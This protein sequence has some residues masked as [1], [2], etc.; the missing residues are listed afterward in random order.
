M[1]WLEA[2]PVFAIAIVVLIL[3]GAIVLRVGGVR[4]LNMLALA[5]PTSISVSAVSAVVMPFIGLTFTPATYGLACVLI[6]LLSA[7][8][9][10][11]QLRR[12]PN[13][14][15][16]SL[17]MNKSPNSGGL[18]R[19]AA[20]ISV[21]VGS[22]GGGFVIGRNLISSIESPENISQTFDNV[23]HLNAVRY[24]AEN[25]NGS[26]LT[27]GNLTEA[28]AGFYPA[29]L[30][31]AMS[32]VYMLSGASVPVTVN[33]VSVVISAVLWPLGCMMLAVR[34]VGKRPIPVM[35]AGFLSA[36]FSGFPYLLIGFGVL[37]SLFAAIALLPATLALMLEVLGLSKLKPLS[38]T[39]PLFWLAIVLPG[40]ALT[41]PSVLVA[42]LLFGGVLLA[43]RVIRELSSRNGPVIQMPGLSWLAG[44]FVYCLAFAVVWSVVRPNLSAAPWGAQQSTS[45][46]IGEVIS[47]A[48]MGAVAAWVLMIFTIAGAYVIFRWQRQLW[49][50][51]AIYLVAGVL[52][53]F[54]SGW[55]SGSL[56]T[57]MVGVWYN[58]PFRLAAILPVVTLPLV[59]VGLDALSSWLLSKMGDWARNSPNWADMPS[60]RPRKLL[61]GI[62]TIAA[63][64]I[65]L[66]CAMLSQSGTL[67]NVKSRIN[68]VF[69][70]E[71]SSDLLSK[72]ELA[73][74]KVVKDFVPENGLIIANPFT[75]A[76]LAYIYSERSVLP[77]H[78]FGDRSEDE[79]F[80]LDHWDE[81]AYNPGVCPVIK[82]L[83]AYW[84][85]D[86]GPKTV[87]RTDDRFLGVFDLELGLAPEVE[88]LASRGDAQLVRTTACD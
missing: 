32:L 61:T 80:L 23:F 79:Q 51:L 29:G 53:M 5:G 19:P 15:W 34:V 22:I 77:P 74:L 49:W 78:M 75:G 50:V 71:E 46:A 86:F 14:R 41:H 9:R 30:H 82:K 55:G 4:G 28:S 69:S 10:F 17:A 7:S 59:I 72:D 21:A 81:A 65:V 33:V 85:L 54:A 58:D 73:L 56:R 45:Q 36:G 63:I 70:F 48:P 52:Y 8:F 12:F 84:A 68:S 62:T 64:S 13:A 37:Y 67:S 11:W 26:S 57:F 44:F 27:L 24:I 87:I 20:L 60:A 35:A 3:P 25:G 38:P 16:H 31:D 2:L 1:A 88:Q 76:S 83:N 42:F 18:W 6:A 40:L 43:A 39:V 66:I 47:S